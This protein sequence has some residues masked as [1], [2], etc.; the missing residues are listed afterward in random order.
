MPIS[1]SGDGS[2]AGLSSVNASVSAAEIGYLDGVT[3]AL[4]T[5]IDSKPTGGA[6]AWSSYSATWTNITVG[7]GTSVTR[8]V[9]IGKTVTV[10]ARFTLG[11]TSAITG[12]VSVSLPVTSIDYLLPTVAP[13]GVATYHDFGS[14]QYF[15]MVTWNNA[16]SAMSYIYS[17]SGTYASVAATASTVPF[18]WGSGDSILF[19]FTYEAA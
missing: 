2:L 19:M 11:S 13:L 15:G 12:N 16:T 18:T 4:Q 6:G 17:A 7:N 9:Q 1:I 5:Q 3:S 14:N 10:Y 8:Y